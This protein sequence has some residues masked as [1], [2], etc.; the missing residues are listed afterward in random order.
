MNVWIRFV[1]V[2][3]DYTSRCNFEHAGPFNFIIHEMLEGHA[4]ETLDAMCH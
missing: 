2:F 4:A 3:L 1:L